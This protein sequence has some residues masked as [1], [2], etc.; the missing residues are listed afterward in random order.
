MRA[1]DAMTIINKAGLSPIKIR[2]AGDSPDCHHCGV[3]D[4]SLFAGL[5]DQ[6]VDSVH[7]LVHDLRLP[8]NGRLFTEG[9]NGHSLYTVRSGMVKL[10]RYLSDGTQRIV[11]VLKPGD[12]A[13]LEITDHAPYE[14]TAIA[15][16]EVAACRIPLEVIERLRKQTP[17]L[18]QQLVHKWHDALRAADSFIAELG[19]GNA[20]QRLARLLLL[21]AQDAQDARIT[22]PGREDVGAMLGI[23]TETASRTVAAFRREGLIHDLDRVGRM[24]RIEAARLDTVAN[25][26]E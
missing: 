18:H 1:K 14:T 16:T 8:A 2:S 21:L 22:L 15:L 20:R 9:E 11:R 17:Q 23:T 25:E 6:A 12:T 10:V 3:R 5:S 19:S 4:Q 7:G 13:G 26:S 24:F